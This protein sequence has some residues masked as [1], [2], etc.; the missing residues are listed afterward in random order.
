MPNTVPE[1]AESADALPTQVIAL[2]AAFNP[3][4]EVL[5]L[6]RPDEVHCGGLWS[7]P[8]GKAEGSEMPLQAALRE[9]LEETGLYGKRWRFL[10]KTTHHYADRTLR[11]ML[12]TCL[13]PDVSLLRCESGY[14]WQPRQ[15][16][17]DLPMPE[18]NGKLLPLLHLP[19]M[20]EFLAEA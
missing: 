6:R 20:D 2:V 15:A 1:T 16:L 18:A 5:L 17:D 19:E 10:G 4:G 8:G 7:F 13:C 12:F 9:L 11:L 14:A 3:D